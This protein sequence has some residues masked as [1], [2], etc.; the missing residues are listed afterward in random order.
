MPEFKTDEVK[1]EVSQKLVS[2]QDFINRDISEV[3]KNGSRAGV[4][5]L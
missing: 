2:L 4:T 5:G 1:V 3:L